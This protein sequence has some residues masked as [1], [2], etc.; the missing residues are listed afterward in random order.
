VPGASGVR[1]G[2]GVG[3]ESFLTSESPEQTLLFG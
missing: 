2:G 1:A 3:A